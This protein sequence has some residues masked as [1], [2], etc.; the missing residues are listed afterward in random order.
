MEGEKLKMIQ[1]L[2]ENNF[3]KETENK[4]YLITDIIMKA[5]R[6]KFAITCIFENG[7]WYILDEGIILEEYTNDIDLKDENI[8]NIV[9]RYGYKLDKITIKKETDKYHVLFD[10]SNIIKIASIV[11][12]YIEKEI[13]EE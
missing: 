2:L 3:V 12:M 5:N 6:H 9:N 7:K 10:V 13:L 8:K 1:T 11:E 4:Y